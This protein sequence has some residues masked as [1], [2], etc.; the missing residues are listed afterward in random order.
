MAQVAHKRLGN[1]NQPRSRSRNWI[2]T[3]NNYMEAEVKNLQ[4]EKWEYVFQK[5]KGKNGTPH[6]QGVV[7]FKH[8]QSLSTVRKMYPRAH[9]EKMKGTKEQAIAYCTKE[10]TRDGEIYKN[11]KIN[12]VTHGTKKKDEK[13]IIDKNFIKKMI[14]ESIRNMRE[15]PTDDLWLGPSDLAMKGKSECEESKDIKDEFC[16]NLRMK[17]INDIL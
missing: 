11:I 4:D 10:S 9:W 15:D 7:F 13:I 5:E 8:P 16:E 2:F 12:I 3:L 14:E 6:L 17:L 1:T